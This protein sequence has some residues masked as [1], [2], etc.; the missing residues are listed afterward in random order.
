MAHRLI[1]VLV[2]FV[3]FSAFAQ[4]SPCLGG[5]PNPRFT[6]NLGPPVQL[7]FEH[8]T[9]HTFSGAPPDVTI[10]GN[11][12]TIVQILTDVPPPPG[13]PAPPACNVQTV[14]LGVLGPGTY[15]VSWIYAVPSGVPGGPPAP[16]ET[17]TFAFAIA[18]EIPA[19]NGPALIALALLLGS[20]AVVI[21]RR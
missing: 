12:I 15:N 2:L 21:L 3:S 1:A 13:P 5:T 17:Y 14:A 9:T 18:P 11:N 16:V 8:L 4:T 20:L 7:T 6:V 10:A 19:L